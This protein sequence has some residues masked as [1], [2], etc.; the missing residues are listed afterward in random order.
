MPNIKELG[1]RMSAAVDGIERV[2]YNRMKRYG[3]LGDVTLMERQCIFLL[4]GG[5]ALSHKIIAGELQVP[6]NF[7]EHIS[8]ELIAKD[9]IEEIQDSRTGGLVVTLSEDGAKKLAKV[10]EHSVTIN[11]DLLRM[12]E[13][14]EREEFLR[15]MTKAYELMKTNWTD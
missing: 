2:L 6:V 13:E 3:G 14:E 11:T 4:A 1:A 7:A 8:E 10:A 5:I 9:W 15:L 12:F